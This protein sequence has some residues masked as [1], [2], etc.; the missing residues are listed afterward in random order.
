MFDSRSLEEYED[1]EAEP[2]VLEQEGP[3]VP[4]LYTESE[5][6]LSILSGPLA[7]LLTSSVVGILS[8]FQFIDQ[9][10]MYLTS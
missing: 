9:K 8:A 7:S 1:L 5:L 2:E 4:E 6:S 3:E 10:P